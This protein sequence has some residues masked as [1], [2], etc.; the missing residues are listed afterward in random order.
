MNKP[1][2]ALIFS[3]VGFN[4]G[5]LNTLPISPTKS[6][7]SALPTKAKP[8]ASV[9]KA[10]PITQ[11]EVAKSPQTANLTNINSI[12]E[13]A[14]DL[15]KLKRKLEIAKAEA[16]IQK[17]RNGG[18]SVAN[19]KSGLNPA[20]VQTT[21]TG[22][23]INQDGRKIAW[24]QFADGGALT[25]NIG[26]KVDKYIVTNINMT[27]VTLSYSSGKKHLQT[28]TIFLKRAYSGIDVINKR[29]RASTMP[30]SLYAPSPVVTSAN[31]HDMATVPPI[32]PIR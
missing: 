7:S 10:V 5:A 18:R 14:T 27:G 4:L 22:V 29:A 16:E 20:K 25:V 1:L 13:N 6:S 28:H 15:L 30:S 19:S 3:S 11:A 8:V 2:L 32:V 12:D 17:I 24:L 9:T 21:V 31:D 26:S 23:A